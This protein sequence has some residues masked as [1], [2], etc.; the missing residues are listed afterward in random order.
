MGALDW[1][2]GARHSPAPSHHVTGGIVFRQFRVFSVEDQ[3]GEPFQRSEVCGSC[4]GIARIRIALSC[5]FQFLPTECAFP[6]Q[7]S[8]REIHHNQ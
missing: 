5:E 2:I 8:V 3:V 7:C 6:S 1:L 4:L